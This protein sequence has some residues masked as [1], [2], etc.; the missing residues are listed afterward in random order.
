MNDNQGGTDLVMFIRYLD[1][2]RRASGRWGIDERQVVVDWTE[3]RA[4]RLKR[5]DDLNERQES[6]DP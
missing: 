4:A 1:T 3:R 6:S 5:P 2:Y